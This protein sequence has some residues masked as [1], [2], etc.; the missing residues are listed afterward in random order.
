M[1]INILKMKKKIA[2]YLTYNYVKYIIL[3]YKNLQYIYVT[4]KMYENC[5]SVNRL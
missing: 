1:D 4:E 5:L 2:Y 3:F